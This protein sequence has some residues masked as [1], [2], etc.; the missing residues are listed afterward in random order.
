M[1]KTTLTINRTYKGTNRSKTENFHSASLHTTIETPPAPPL[2]PPQS[3]VVSW[4]MDLSMVYESVV[5]LVV[6]RRLF[7]DSVGGHY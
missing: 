4:T 1:N 3:L 7:G 2:P 6:H 5:A